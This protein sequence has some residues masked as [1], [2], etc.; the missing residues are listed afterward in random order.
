[1]GRVVRSHEHYA[2]EN[3]GQEGCRLV[4]TNTVEFVVELA[5][6]EYA[7]EAMILSFAGFNALAKIKVHAEE[8][9]EAVR[10]MAAVKMAGF[11]DLLCGFA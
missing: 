6:E 9:T 4:L 11:N 2:L 5:E 10:A 3:L 7:I 1:M 8:A